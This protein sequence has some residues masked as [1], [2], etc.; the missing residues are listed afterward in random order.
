M[1]TKKLKK[2]SINKMD[3]FPVIGEQEQ[4]AL[5]G[6]DHPL[7]DTLRWALYDI[8]L[9]EQQIMDFF[10]EFGDGVN[11]F[12]TNTGKII[13]NNLE[14]AATF[15]LNRSVGGTSPIGAPFI[16]FENTDI[17]GF[18]TFDPSNLGWNGSN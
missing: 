13:G 4:M 17:Y 18:G 2:L 14:A 9:S 3:S 7:G 11:N 5:K 16:V 6:G 1:K 10:D 15:I 8:G 12:I